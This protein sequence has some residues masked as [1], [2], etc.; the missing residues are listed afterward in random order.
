MQQLADDA[1]KGQSSCRDLMELH[2]ELHPQTPSSPSLSRS[3]THP[4]A[5]Y[6]PFTHFT[7]STV[8]DFAISDTLNSTGRFRKAERNPSQCLSRSDLLSLSSPPFSGPPLQGPPQ[9]RT[10]FMPAQPLSLRPLLTHLPF[11]LNRG[12][13]PPM[14]D[15]SIRRLCDGA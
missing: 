8:L 6:K 10:N 5:S 4:P 11:L 9:E 2:L 3:I 12:Y 1:G 14:S 7:S 15:L 13:L